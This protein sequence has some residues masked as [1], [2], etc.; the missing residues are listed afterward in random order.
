M[1]NLSIRLFKKLSK[2]VRITHNSN[3]TKSSRNRRN[4]LSDRELCRFLALLFFNQNQR[5]STFFGIFLV[6]FNINQR[7][8]AAK[9]VLFL[10]VSEWFNTIKTADLSV[11]RRQ[12]IARQDHSRIVI[13][14]LDDVEFALGIKLLRIK[15]VLY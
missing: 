7:F 12:H 10:N 4:Y 14:E 15:D 9:T 8:L 3:K 2:I 6:F 11:G 13:F 5:F 1:L